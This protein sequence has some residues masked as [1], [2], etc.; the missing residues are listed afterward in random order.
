MERAQ[1]GRATCLSLHSGTAAGL[2]LRA[3]CLLVGGGQRSATAGE[4]R[5]GPEPDLPTP[6]SVFVG[7]EVSYVEVG[8]AFRNPAVTQPLPASGKS[9]DKD[10]PWSFKVQKVPCKFR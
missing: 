4:R 8:P 5:A 3:L 2:G 6:S 1:R 10:G 9:E 7:N